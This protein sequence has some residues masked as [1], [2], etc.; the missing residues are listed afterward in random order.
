MA[1]GATEPALKPG[2]ETH[3]SGSMSAMAVACMKL[4]EQVSPILGVLHAG[5]EGAGLPAGFQT[6]E[7]SGE[8][9]TSN[10]LANPAA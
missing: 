10:G 6:S 9:V 2:C 1:P 7:P 3:I 8:Q 5:L 4:R